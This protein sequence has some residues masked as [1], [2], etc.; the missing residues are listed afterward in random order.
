[1]ELDKRIIEGKKPLDCYDTQEAK[2]YIDE[3]ECQQRNS[4]CQTFGVLDNGIK[5]E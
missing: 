2:D 1:M 3:F 4:E 5:E